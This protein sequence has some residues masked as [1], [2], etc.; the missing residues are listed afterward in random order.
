MESGASAKAVNESLKL[1]KSQ[2]PNTAAIIFT[3]D[4]DAGKI[5]C[6]HQVPQEAADKGLKASEWVQQVCELMDG[7]G[8]GEG[9][10]CA[11][12]GKECRL[13]EVLRL[14]EDFAKL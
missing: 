14:A 5:R 12:H 4:N 10:V 3:V 13:S 6:L 7:K 1:L 8:G 2:S 9:L 11:G